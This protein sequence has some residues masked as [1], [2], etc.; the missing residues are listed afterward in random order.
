VNPEFVGAVR[1]KKLLAGEFEPSGVK[2]KGLGLASSV[3]AGGIVKER[4]DPVSMV[5]DDAAS[6]SSIDG[7]TAKRPFTR[8]CFFQ[9]IAAILGLLRVGVRLLCDGLCVNSE[10]VV[11]RWYASS[12]VRCFVFRYFAGT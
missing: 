9:D 8:G 3:S 1:L 4:G 12:Q 7:R 11:V 10:N 2:E 5:C 6:W